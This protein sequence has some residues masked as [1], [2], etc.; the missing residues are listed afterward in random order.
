[1]YSLALEPASSQFCSTPLDP[2]SL[3][4]CCFSLS[5]PNPEKRS[6][7]SIPKAGVPLLRLSLKFL[8]LQSEGG[9]RKSQPKV[10]ATKSLS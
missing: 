3:G 5:L 6:Y 4:D 1:M 10:H 9:A 7:V 2:L 8:T